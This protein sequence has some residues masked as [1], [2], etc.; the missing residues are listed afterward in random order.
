MGLGNDWAVEVRDRGMWMMKM[1]DNFMC[2]FICR[3]YMRERKEEAEPT[4]AVEV[5]G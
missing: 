5:L 4:A 1:G 3:M 2:V